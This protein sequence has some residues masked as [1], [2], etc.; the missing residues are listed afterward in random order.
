MNHFTET[1][2]QSHFTPSTF[3]NLYCT[4]IRLL[5]DPCQVMFHSSL[6]GSIISFPRT[7]D[8]IVFIVGIINTPETFFQLHIKN[9]V[10]QDCL[11]QFELTILNQLFR[12]H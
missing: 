9:H 2:H 12:L 6:S 8:F 3:Q 5:V 4:N 7:L 11:P 1:I 10:E